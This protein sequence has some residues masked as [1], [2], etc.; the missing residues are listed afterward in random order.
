VTKSAFF[1]S[2][3]GF[4]LVKTGWQPCKEEARLERCTRFDL[5]VQ[6]VVKQVAF[7]SVLGSKMSHKQLKQKNIR[8]FCR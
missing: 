4:V 5:I 7:A 6:R 3:S 2:R 1:V 8:A